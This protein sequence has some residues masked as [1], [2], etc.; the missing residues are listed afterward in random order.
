VTLFNDTRATVLVDDC[1]GDYCNP[2]QPVV[3]LA[4]A[5]AGDVNAACAASGKYMTSWRLTTTTGNTVGFIAVDTPRKQD[6]LVYPVSAA[7][8]SRSQPAAHR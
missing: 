5:A 7:T 1:R 4:P 2:D 8:D 6:G 3:R